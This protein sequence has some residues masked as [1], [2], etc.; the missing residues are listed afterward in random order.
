MRLSQTD[1]TER[2]D[3]WYLRHDGKTTVSVLGMA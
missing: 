1:P 2:D 3:I